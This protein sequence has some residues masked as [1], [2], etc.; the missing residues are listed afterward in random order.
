MITRNKSTH[1]LQVLPQMHEHAHS[2]VDAVLLWLQKQ[3]LFIFFRWQQSLVKVAFPLHLPVLKDKIQQADWQ[4]KVLGHFL[5]M[6]ECVELL[7]QLL[8][9][10]CPQAQFLSLSWRFMTGRT[11]A[12]FSSCGFAM[13]QTVGFELDL[14]TFIQDGLH[15]QVVFKSTSDVERDGAILNRTLED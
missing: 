13:L 14:V 15:L 5:G 9:L 1:P 10:L 8:K 12:C 6:N 3:V 2:C 7:L 11:Q 4:S